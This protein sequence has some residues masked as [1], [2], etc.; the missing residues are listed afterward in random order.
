MWLVPGNA[1]A[2]C[3]MIT[4]SAGGAKQIEPFIEWRR[5]ASKRQCDPAFGSFPTR[6]PARSPRRLPAT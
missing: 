5:P 4:L 6:W 2:T 1:I 3:R